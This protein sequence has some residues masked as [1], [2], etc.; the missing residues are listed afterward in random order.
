MGWL[1]ES[2]S[3]QGRG[4]LFAGSG[5]GVCCVEG[6]VPRNARCDVSIG[7]LDGNESLVSE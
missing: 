5:S 2:R 7:H 6:G 1:V 3:G 4:M